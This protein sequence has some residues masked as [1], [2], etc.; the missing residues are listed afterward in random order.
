MTVGTIT[1]TFFRTHK[2]VKFGD[3]LHFAKTT[4]G[5]GK[6]KYDWKICTVS[7]LLVLSNFN[8]SINLFA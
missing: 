7:V 2:V 6:F 8:Q 1:K 5:K 4:L 3:R